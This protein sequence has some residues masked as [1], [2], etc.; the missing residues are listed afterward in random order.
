[1]SKDLSKDVLGAIKRKTG[2]NI[3]ASS[4]GKV[5]GTVQPDTLENEAELKKLIRRV[6]NMAN[7]KLS[8]AKLNEIAH[9]IKASGV[10]TSNLESLM[11]MMMK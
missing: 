2:K 11:K 4:V 10:K 7:I 8:D 9:T 5:A 3:S 6:A 1:M